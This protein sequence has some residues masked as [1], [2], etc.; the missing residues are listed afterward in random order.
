MGVGYQ[1]CQAGS[2]DGYLGFGVIST[3]VMALSLLPAKHMTPVFRVLGGQGHNTATAS[4]RLE[5][6]CHNI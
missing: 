2:P 6:Y 5:L 4:V 3:P 1:K